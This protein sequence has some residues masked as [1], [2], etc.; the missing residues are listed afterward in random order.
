MAFALLAFLVVVSR[1]WFF[2]N[3]LIDTDEQLYLLVGER[4]LDGALPY[5]DLFD[6][7]PFGL[8]EIYSFAAWLTPD[9]VIGYQV[10]AAASVLATAWAIFLGAR[11]LVDAGPALGG[12][13]AYV[14]WLPVF[15]GIGGQTPV[16]YN[17]PVAIAAWGMIALH[18][19]ERNRQILWPGLAVMGLIG[20]ALQV[21]Y[22]VVFEGV[23]FGL[24][25]MWLEWRR[26]RSI[27][28]VAANGL[29]WMCAALVPS[30]LSAG[31]F[32]AKD[33]FPAFWYAN[34]VSILS[35]DAGAGLSISAVAR[36]AQQVIALAPF[37]YAAAIAWKRPEQSDGSTQFVKIWLLAAVA[38]YLAF[39]TWYDH[40]VLPLLVPLSLFVALAA[41]RFA[42]PGR[43][44]L[45]ICA[46][47]LVAGMVRSSVLLG[48]EGSVQDMERVTAMIR[49][50]L[51]HGCLYVASGPPGL[52][53]TT[54]AC[55]VTPYV[56]PS[57]LLS[58]KYAG[59]LGVRQDKAM[60]S[61]LDKDPAVIITGRQFTDSNAV[62]EQFLKAE[63]ARDYVFMARLR[64]GI[65]RLGV[66][67]RKDALLKP[68]PG[69]VPLPEHRANDV[70][71]R[72]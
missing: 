36:L 66:W 38:G 72:I 57:H 12:A 40:Y 24:A 27:L 5:R 35:R 1:A 26:S 7:K 63:L 18:Q 50:Y 2:G 53:S 11:Q 9:S 29:A 70:R 41:P 16:F 64:M 39:G 33:A 37:W 42:R 3:R 30:L 54:D 31:Y 23:C 22:T 69:P 10:L 8:F 65:R 52:Y 48:T 45:R 4:M 44:I 51:H 25:L 59:T 62:N 15:I 43:A 58:Q 34:V 6:V 61:L 49:P 60:V 14:V 67:V 19:G 21:K 13:A 28:R 68:G 20:L 47:G 32:A 46:I 56:F 17:L 55:V 71:P